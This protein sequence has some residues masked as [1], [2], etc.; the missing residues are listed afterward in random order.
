MK[1]KSEPFFKKRSREL[2]LIGFFLTPALLVL[3]VYRILPLFWNLALSFLHWAPASRRSS[4][5]GITMR[6]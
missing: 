2:L 6:K 3:F 5:A 4:P 1:S